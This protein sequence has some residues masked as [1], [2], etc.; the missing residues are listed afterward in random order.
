[1]QV[2]EAEVDDDD[3]NGSPLRRRRCFAGAVTGIVLTL[4]IA[5]PLV[6]QLAN[7][8]ARW[9]P[10]PLANVASGTAH[11]VAVLSAIAAI[12]AWA[13]VPAAVALVAVQRRD[14]I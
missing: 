2:F 10:S 9:M 11:D 1:M 13:L 7:G 8:T 4:V 14:V 3:A 6:I 12:A 5:P